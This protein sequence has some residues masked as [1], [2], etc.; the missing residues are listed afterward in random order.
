MKLMGKIAWVTGAAGGLGRGI[1]KALSADGASVAV[2]DINEKGLAETK[3]EMAAC[4][5]ECMTIRC[6]V[7]SSPDVARMFGEIVARFGTLDVLVNNAAI[8]PN[9]PED[10]ARRKRRYT[11]VTTPVPRQSLQ[12]TSSL[13]DDDWHRYWHLSP[14]IW[15]AT[16]TSLSDKSSAQTAAW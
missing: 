7:S 2:C 16:A 1:A 12:L 10:E 4:D 9:R 6:D 5:S 11:Y 3:S 14:S 13:T 8:V 15:Q